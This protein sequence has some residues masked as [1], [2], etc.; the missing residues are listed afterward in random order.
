LRSDR[1]TVEEEEEE[2]EEN[3]WFKSRSVPVLGHYP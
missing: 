1:D 3:F 2:E